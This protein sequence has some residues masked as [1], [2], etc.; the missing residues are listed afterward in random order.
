MKALLILVNKCGYCVYHLPKLNT[1][2]NGYWRTQLFHPHGN[3]IFI[4]FPEYVHFKGSRRTCIC[5]GGHWKKFKCQI[6]LRNF[7]HIS[8]YL[9]SITSLTIWHTTAR[10][11]PGW[12]LEP[13]TAS[14]SLTLIWGAWAIFHCFPTCIDR[15]LDWKW[16][17]CHP[18]ETTGQKSWFLV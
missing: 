6:K 10:T 5:G 13:E 8:W 12:T 9:P 2:K 4:L 14:L 18:R 15:E 17:S 3:V 16:G 11:A 1:T 7:L